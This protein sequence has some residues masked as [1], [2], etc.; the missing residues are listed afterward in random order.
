MLSSKMKANNERWRCLSL[1][2]C[3]QAQEY[4]EKCEDA[5]MMYIGKSGSV[6]SR[7]DR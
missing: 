3:C 6:P 2:R 7:I 5:R 4:I 1:S